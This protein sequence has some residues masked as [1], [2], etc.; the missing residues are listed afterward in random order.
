MGN[1]GTYTTPSIPTE[2]NDPPQISGAMTDWFSTNSGA[3]ADGDALINPTAAAITTT[4]AVPKYFG[5]FLH[6]VFEVEATSPQGLTP[7]A[8]ITFAWSE[9]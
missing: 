5:D 1:G 6:L 2:S 7:T 8:Q 4:P 9:V 3:P